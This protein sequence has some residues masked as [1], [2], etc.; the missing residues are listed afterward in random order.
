MDSSRF[1][2]WTRRRFGMAAMGGLAAAWLGLAHPDDGDAAAAL[3]TP[4]G[5]KCHKKSQKCRSSNCLRAPFTVTAHWTNPDTDHD[6]LLFVPPEHADDPPESRVIPYGCPEA[7]TRCEEA[8]PFACISEDARGPGDEITT[9]YKLL[10]GAYQYWVELGGESPRGDLTVV[11]R[12]RD[13]KLVRSWPS[14]AN[15]SSV[16]EIGWHVFDINGA[17]GS[18]KSVNTLPANGIPDYTIVCPT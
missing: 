14:P 18:V 12:N 15:P 1:D 4:T 16:N 8:Y 6:T 5:G 7:T 17:T 11:L 10:P 9:F 3:C 13:G 2:A